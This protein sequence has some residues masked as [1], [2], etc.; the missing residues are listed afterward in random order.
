MFVSWRECNLRLASLN[1]NAT[2]WLQRRMV[3][4]L[5]LPGYYLST[6]QVM[7]EKSRLISKRKPCLCRFLGGDESLPSCMGIITNLDLLSWCIFYG[8]DPMGFITIQLTTI[9]ENSFGTFSKHHGEKQIQVYHKHQPSMKLVN[10]PKPTWIAT[11]MSCWYLG[12]MDY[13]TPI[14]VGCRS[15]K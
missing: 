10:R 15:R 11:G 4:S 13:F 1:G 2:P 3:G 7:A 14:Q 5:A 8:F 9:W 12:S 6:Y